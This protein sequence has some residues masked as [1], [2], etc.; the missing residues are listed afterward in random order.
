MAKIYVDP[1]DG[2]PFVHAGSGAPLDVPRWLKKL[3][4]FFEE[5]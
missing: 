3:I 5:Y 2:F 4:T 1:E